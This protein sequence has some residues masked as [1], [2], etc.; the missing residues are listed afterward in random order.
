MH[1]HE[2]RRKNCAI[3]LPFPCPIPH[4]FKINF[5]NECK[6]MLN[7]CVNVWKETFFKWV[8]SDIF[9]PSIEKYFFLRLY[10]E[11]GFS[12]ASVECVLQFT[13][14]L[15][16]KKHVNGLCSRLFNI[17]IQFFLLPVFLSAVLRAFRR[18]EFSRDFWNTSQ[19]SNVRSRKK[20]TLNCAI[21]TRKLFIITWN[22]KFREKSAEVIY[23]PRYH[24]RNKKKTIFS[25][26][27]KRLREEKKMIFC[28]R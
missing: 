16:E 19:D 22:L 18:K 26:K 4:T 21:I 9:F 12:L 10:T 25:W 6:C 20:K 5:N 1:L 23:F 7:A 8:I 13:K 17:F 3:K 14:T 15:Y 24:I 2:W 11:I 27:I 28:C